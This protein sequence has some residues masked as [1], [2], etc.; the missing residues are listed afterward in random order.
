MIFAQWKPIEELVGQL[1]DYRKILI[2]GCATCVAECAAGGEKE[3]E[4]L[5]PLLRMALD[6]EGRTVEIDTC[7]LEKQCEWEFIEEMAEKAAE[8]EVVLSLACGL[9]VQAVAQRFEDIPVY[10][11]VNTSAL[12]MR[13][14]EGIWSSRCAACGDCVLSETFGLD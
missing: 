5:E 13:V 2:A 10:P 14:E 11:G 3:V 7:T 1:K 9:G 8:A 6:K 4:T 12:T